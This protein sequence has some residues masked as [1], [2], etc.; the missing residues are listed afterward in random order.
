MGNDEFLGLLDGASPRTPAG[1]YAG[2]PTAPLRGRAARRARPLM[3]NE[4][5]FLG[6]LDGA[7]PRTP[8]GRVS[9]CHRGVSRADQHGGWTGKLRNTGVGRTATGTTKAD[10]M[11]FPRQLYA[12]FE[13]SGAS[14]APSLPIRYTSVGIWVPTPMKVLAAACAQLQTDGWF[15][16]TRPGHLLDAGSGDGR[17][18]ALLSQ[19]DPTRLVYGIEHDPRLY[20][21]AVHNLET[22]K[23]TGLTDPSR[24]HLIE[25]DY[26]DVAT[27][28]GARI[29]LRDTHLVF[30]YPD[31]NP[32]RL[33]RFMAAHGGDHTKVC[34]LSH[35]RTLVLD[36]L[37]LQHRSD[38]RVQ[39]EPPWQLSI[40]GMPGHRDTKTEPVPGGFLSRR[41]V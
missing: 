19:L 5:E 39:N 31:G 9:S 16:R 26:C 23:P 30:N 37:A 12:V 22:L 3:G 2:T 10:L 36:G 32:Q 33:A 40:Y 38:V 35:D 41:P 28:R 13:R 7:S 21:R 18:A 24:V 6:L 15:A 20:A 4:D 1:R 11:M 34:L 14:F 25:G 8:A 29:N 27:Y 17:V